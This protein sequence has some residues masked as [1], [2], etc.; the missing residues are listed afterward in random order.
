LHSIR[1]G[2][3]QQGQGQSNTGR[4]QSQQQEASRIQNLL[5]QAFKPVQNNQVQGQ[6]Q[7]S[8]GMTGSLMQ[9]NVQSGTAN[10]MQ[11]LNQGQGQNMIQQANGQLQQQQSILQGNGQ[12]Q[13]TVN[14]QN[15]IQGQNQQTALLTS[16]LQQLLAT[17]YF[18][19]VAETFGCFDWLFAD[20]FLSPDRY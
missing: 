4:S 14:Q 13:Q 2:I 15:A 3:T 20:C 6:M 19:V 16:L 11:G 12:V 18:L 7:N 1:I 8:N 17:Q 5:S 10:I 9:Q